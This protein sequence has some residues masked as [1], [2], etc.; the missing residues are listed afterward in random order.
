MTLLFSQSAIDLNLHSDQ[1]LRAQGMD[2]AAVCGSHPRLVEISEKALQAG[3]P[4]LS[5]LAAYR[6][7][8]VEGFK[9]QRLF[10][11]GGST[12]TGELISSELAG[13]EAL[14]AAVCTVGEQVNRHISQ[15]FPE[16]PA[17]ALALDGLASAA[18]EALAARLCREF[19]AAAAAEG[20]KAGHPL[21]P[22]M[23][24]WTVEAGQPQVFSLLDAS[25]IGCSLTGGGLI[26]PLKS[27]SFVVGLGA[28]LDSSRSSC[29]FCTMAERCFYRPAPAG[30]LL[31]P[32]AAA[33]PAGTE[34]PL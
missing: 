13:A 16:D 14:I 15:I 30:A 8:K 27:L 2:P 5:P 9:H 20:T 7:L 18:V 3:L 6:R 19:E 29:D 21:N 28:T 31:D 4:L 11:E 10:L 26:Q 17:L 33:H 22:G 25:M 24:G 32:S 23:A 1:V 34:R 12:L